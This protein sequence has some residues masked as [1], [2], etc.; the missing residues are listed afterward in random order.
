MGYHCAKTVV[1]YSG[2]T[3]VHHGGKTVVHYCGKTVAYF[4]S[5]TV[6]HHCTKTVVYYHHGKTVVCYHCHDGQT[7]ISLWCTTHLFYMEEVFDTEGDCTTVNWRVIVQGSIIS[8]IGANGE[9]HWLELM[10]GKRMKW[11]NGD[12]M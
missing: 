3:V 8:H 12:C 6:V 1:Y 4:H 7:G 5:K 2:E 10:E 9:S 11:V